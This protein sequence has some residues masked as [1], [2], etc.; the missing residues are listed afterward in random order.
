MMAQ[1]QGMQAALQAE[2]DHMPAGH[3]LDMPALEGMASS[4]ARGGSGQ[5]L[6][7][8]SLKEQ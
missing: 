4:C 6:G 1:Q 5:V 2:W 7:E 3:G 8:I